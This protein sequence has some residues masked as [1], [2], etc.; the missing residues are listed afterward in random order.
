MISAKDCV[1]SDEKNLRLYLRDSDEELLK[2]V[3]AV[4][5]ID[6]ENLLQKEELKRGIK[7]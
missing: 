4:G 1:Q 7:A 2:G 5:I 3:K 6:T